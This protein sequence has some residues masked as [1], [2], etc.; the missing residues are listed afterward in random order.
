M[1][2]GHT[3]FSTL[4]AGNVD[5]AIHRLESE[6]LNVP[7]N[8]LQALNVISVQ[9]LV[10]RGQER[11]RRVQE[12]VEI[13]GADPTTGSLRVNTVFTYDPVTDKF[14]YHGRSQVYA[15]IAEKRGWSREQLEDEIRIR[16]MILIAMKEQGILDYISVS[17][18]FQAYNID[19][20]G[21]IESIGDLKAFLKRGV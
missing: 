8:M 2:T 13:A 21:V 14:S 12:I 1:N 16:K 18:L 15:D 6:P 9:A 17:Q 5:A 20:A 11:I 4:H 7:R 10:Y 19:S 3:T